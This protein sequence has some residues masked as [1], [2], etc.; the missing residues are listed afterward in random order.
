MNWPRRRRHAAMRRRPIRWLGLEQVEGRQLLSTVSEVVPVGDRFGVVAVAASS[1]DGIGRDGEVHH[2]H[3]FKGSGSPMTRLHAN[4]VKKDGLPES[5][6]VHLG[7]HVRFTPDLVGW[8]VSAPGSSDAA[9]ADPVYTPAQ[10]KQAYGFDQVPYDGTGQTIAIVDA[11]SDPNIFGD[12]DVFDQTFSVSRFNPSSLYTAYGPSSQ[13]LS[14]LQPNGPPPT[15]PPNTNWG[16]EISL[17]VEW[18]TRSRPGPISCSS[19]PYPI[20]APTC[21]TR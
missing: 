3:H 2:A 10:I 16:A 6:A 14:V 12:A 11:Y 21:I 8:G 13:W 19:R 17:D 9:P 18:R 4:P 5:R 15:A 7:R 1:L 20:V